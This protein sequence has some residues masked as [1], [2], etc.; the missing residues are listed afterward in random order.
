MNASYTVKTSSYLGREG[1]LF[2]YYNG[3]VGYIVSVRD[4]GYSGYE[5]TVK[6]LSKYWLLQIWQVFV[7][8]LK[9]KK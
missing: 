6:P 1:E 5:M 7:L 9:F 3:N 8:R 4:N 2:L